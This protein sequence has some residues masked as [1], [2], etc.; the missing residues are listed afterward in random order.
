MK[1]TIPFLVCLV[2]TATLALA[3]IGSLAVTTSESQVCAYDPNRNWVVL[4]NNDT[5]SVYI[6]ISSD[7]NALT[8]TNGIL[9]PAGGVI[10]IS[11]T[12]QNAAQNKITA[13][14]STNTASLT[15]QYGNE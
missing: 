5:N 6:K 3:G 4:Q 10:S 13:I 8:V 2:L 7:T 1:K 12:G 11:R 14:T 15:Y 9:L